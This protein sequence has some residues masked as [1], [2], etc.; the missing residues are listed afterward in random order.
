VDQAVAHL[1][2]ADIYCSKP[3]NSGIRYVITHQPLKNLVSSVRSEAFALDPMRASDT[4][5]EIE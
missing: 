3:T 5:Q 2:A 1:E 4:V